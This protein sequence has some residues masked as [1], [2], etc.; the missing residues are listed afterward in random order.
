MK[1]LVRNIVVASEK[2]AEGITSL[3]C[4]VSAGK[5][6]VHTL[7]S[8]MEEGRRSTGKRLRT[9]LS[10]GHSDLVQKAAGRRLEVQDLMESIAKGRQARIN[11]IQDA[12]ANSHNRLAQEEARRRSGSLAY[13]NA[14]AA[15]RCQ[16]RREW[17][18]VAANMGARRKRDLVEDSRQA[19]PQKPEDSLALEK[20]VFERLADAPNGCRLVD[21]EH[22]FGAGRFQIDRALKNLISKGKVEKRIRQ[23]YAI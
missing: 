7:M 6:R 9:E 22:E 11:D 21:L 15:D 20:A 2:R 19:D 16:A 10:R 13:M 12:L 3:R 5:N 14:I 23:Y 17:Q 18:S 8:D 1:D 4:E